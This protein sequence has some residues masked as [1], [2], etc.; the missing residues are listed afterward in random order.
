MRIICEWPLV[1]EHP[2]R[3]LCWLGLVSA[4]AWLWLGDSREPTRHADPLRVR[5]QRDLV[6]RSVGRRQAKLDVYLPAEQS[7]LPGQ[8]SRRPAILAIHGGSWIGG[9]KFEYG[10]AFDRLAAHGYVV[11]A[12][13]YLLARPWQ[14]SWPEVLDDLRAAVA[15]IR[16][17]AREFDVDPAR[18][19]AWGTGAGGHLAMLLGT[20]PAGPEPDG[21]DLSVQAVVS[22]CGPTDLVDL[23]TARLLPGDPARIFLGGNADSWPQR[24]RSASPLWNLRSNVPPMLLAHGTD[25][26]FVPLEQSVRMAER[27]S[28]LGVFHRLIVVPGARHGFEPRIGYPEARDLLPEIFAFLEQVWQPP[29][30]PKR[31]SAF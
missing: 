10:G 14:P 27:L 3:T 25:D 26:P 30:P 2:M 11:Y 23:V 29:S 6:Y 7:G 22:L 1:L 13:D 18:L 28:S 5:V 21:T 31:A 12:A 17:N 9:S 4:V 16:R 15:W 20:L 19:T 24:A 8:G